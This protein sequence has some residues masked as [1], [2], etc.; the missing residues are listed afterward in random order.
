MQAFSS[1]AFETIFH[2]SL[3]EGSFPEL[4]APLALDPS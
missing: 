4:V 1:V 3:A 2:L